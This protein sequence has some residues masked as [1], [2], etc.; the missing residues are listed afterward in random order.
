VIGNA[1]PQRMPGCVV[2][3]GDVSDSQ[4]GSTNEHF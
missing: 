2:D 3:D 1:G 4:K